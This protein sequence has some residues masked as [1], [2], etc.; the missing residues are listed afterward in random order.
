MLAVR[1]L[2]RSLVDAERSERGVGCDTYTVASVWWRQLLP[3]QRGQRERRHFVHQ[4]VGCK[5]QNITLV[6][7]TML[8]R[9]ES[10]S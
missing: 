9:R 1:T 7:Y 8:K 4:W 5:N 2:R 10:K 6:R 3:V